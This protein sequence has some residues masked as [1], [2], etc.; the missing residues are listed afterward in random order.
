MFLEWSWRCVVT[1]CCDRN[2]R[3]LPWTVIGWDIFDFFS[4]TIA[5]RITKFATNCSFYGPEEVLLLFVLIGNPRWLPRTLDWLRHFPLL[6]NHC[7][8]D[9]QTFHKCSFYSPEEVLLLFVVI[10]KWKW[11]L[12][13]L[14][15]WDIFNFRRTTALVI[16]K[17][18]QMF[19][20]LFLLV[21][22]GEIVFFQQR[23]T[24]TSSPKGMKCQ[25]VIAHQLTCQ[26]SDTGPIVIDSISI[27]LYPFYL[28][29]TDGGCKKNRNY[30]AASQA[31]RKRWL[32]YPSCLFIISLLLAS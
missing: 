8:D 27:L 5:L 14:I 4:R 21:W 20:L 26:L 15:Y 25:I 1:F 17:L 12:S 23:V 29:P 19:L 2:P 24:V 18:A 30:P 22:I 7:M 10:R 31:C 6:K 13:T 9:C 32:G 3:W 28:S 11:P 16:T